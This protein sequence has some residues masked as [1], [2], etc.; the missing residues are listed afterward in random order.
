MPYKTA[1]FFLTKSYKQKMKSLIL[2]V[3]LVI[4]QYCLA[5][6]W[7]VSG[8]M[9]AIRCATTGGVNSDMSLINIYHNSSHYTITLPD[10]TMTEKSMDFPCLNCDKNPSIANYPLLDESKFVNVIYP[11]EANG[12]YIGN[13]TIAMSNGYTYQVYFNETPSVYKL[14]SNGN[15]LESIS[16]G[17]PLPGFYFQGGTIVRDDQDESK[18]YVVLYGSFRR[19]LPSR[20]YVRVSVNPLSV[21]HVYNAPISSGI[22]RPYKNI[23][24]FFNDKTIIAFDFATLQEKRVVL[25][26][27]AIFVGARPDPSEIITTGCVDTTLPYIDFPDQDIHIAL[28][29]QPD[30]TTTNAPSTSESPATTVDPTMNCWTCEPGYSHWWEQGREKPEDLCACFKNDGSTTKTPS[31]TTTKAPSQGENIS[32]ENNSRVNSGAVVIGITTGILAVALV[33]MLL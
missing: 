18:F 5:A 31:T 3:L 1:M 2:L 4:A 11:S 9:R 28:T 24:V 33:A 15:V 23:V 16:L 25:E 30:T 26:K 29:A 8:Y 7:P 22:P 14:D 13:Q 21:V 12:M 17:V 19:D 20:T 32:G 10:L 6:E 27:M